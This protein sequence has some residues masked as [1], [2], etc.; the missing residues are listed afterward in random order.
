MAALT[1]NDDIFDSAY[2]IML[3]LGEPSH[4]YA[5]MQYVENLTYGV[6]KLGPAT[7]Y[8]TL[9]KLEK[10]GYIESVESSDS[11]RKL[12]ELTEKGITALMNEI[13]KRE[14]MAWHGSEFIKR[15]CG[16]GENV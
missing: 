4:G 11:R 9:K 15:Y 8:T 13:K 2:Y 12:Y 16:G 7:L 14:M 10:A 1:L 6:F 5:I 3:S